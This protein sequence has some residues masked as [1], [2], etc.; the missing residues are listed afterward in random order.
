MIANTLPQTFFK[1]YNVLSLA[2]M[3]VVVV[4]GAVRFAKQFRKV[5][6]KLWRIRSMGDLIFALNQLG[7][8]KIIYDVLGAIAV[9]ILLFVVLGRAR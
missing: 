2:L 6:N 4:Q 7:L 9:I 1:F 3:L 8:L 5:S